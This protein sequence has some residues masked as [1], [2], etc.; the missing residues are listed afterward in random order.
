[1]CVCGN[2]SVCR[3]T[4]MQVLCPYVC[5]H[6]CGSQRET[7]CPP[8]FW[9]KTSHWPGTLCEFQRSNSGSQ[10]CKTKN[11]PAWATYPDLRFPPPPL[12]NHFSSPKEENLG[13]FI[14]WSRDSGEIK[15]TAVVW[16]AQPAVYTMV[17]SDRNCV[18][19]F[20]WGMVTINDGFIKGR[21]AP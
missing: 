2:M 15:G 9:D 14:C 19:F 13:I 4:C 10:I 17:T 16:I 8:Y 3:C 21:I 12:R 20:L 18:F 7:C 5:A 11:F 1:M 6:W